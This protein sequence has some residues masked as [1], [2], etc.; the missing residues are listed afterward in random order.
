MNFVIFFA[1]VLLSFFHCCNGNQSSSADLQAKVAL[2]H[3]GKNYSAVRLET[4]IS[5]DHNKYCFYQIHEPSQ[6]V[7]WKAIFCIFFAKQG[8]TFNTMSSFYSVGEDFD[9][10]PTKT[11]YQALSA[12]QSNFCPTG[13]TTHDEKTQLVVHPSGFLVWLISFIPTGDSVPITYVIND[14]NLVVLESFSGRLG[15][16]ATGIGLY[17]GAV[18]FNS[19]QVGSNYYL[20]DTNSTRRTTVLDCQGGNCTTN[21]R[22]TDIDNYWNETSNQAAVNVHW[23][24][25]RHLDYYQ[26]ILARNNIDGKGL[27]SMSGLITSADG[28][29]TLFPHMVNYGTSY[30]DVT[31]T[32]GGILYGSGDGITYGNLVSLDIVGH[33]MFHGALISGSTLNGS[34]PSGYPGALQEA[35]SDIFGAMGERYVLGES[36]NTWRIGEDF[37]TPLIPGDA[38]R[39]MDN[40]HMSANIS[41]VTTNGN[42]QHMNESYNGTGDNGGVHVNCGIIEKAFYLYSKGGSHPYGGPTL[43]GVGADVASLVFYKA[44]PY[45]TQYSD[46]NA[47]R[48][49][50]MHSALSLYG[51]S[52]L[53][54]AEIQTAMSVVGVGSTYGNFTT[55]M[56]NTDFESTYLPWVLS[57]A[58]AIAWIT[59]SPGFPGVDNSKGYM[60]FGINDGASGSLSS[61]PYTIMQT[62]TSATLSF[63]LRIYTADNSNTPNDLFYVNLLDS[64]TGSTI[65]SLA[66]FSN[67]SPQKNAWF[68]MTYMGLNVYKSHNITVQFYVSLDASLQTNF[69]IDDACFNQNQN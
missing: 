44:L 62:S 29:T 1:L 15:A 63:Y 53:A 42:P 52:N 47:F 36:N 69:E 50:L 16:A 38:L 54:Y 31:Y 19:N 35:L 68:K 39:F 65:A 66:A 23:S 55:T 12:A 33:E 6:I 64:N 13:C 25:S 28:S 58:T 41:G 30:N 26:N 5:M 17:N 4:T 46:F 7:F 14:T 37:Y 51:S 9:P 61:G 48:T 45:L 49:G 10:N 27:T 56:V 32:A 60:K 18:S 34:Y 40:P 57:G 2:S 21:Y 22:I 43:V 11:V 3:L 59:Y 67:L 24:A 8:E 20:E